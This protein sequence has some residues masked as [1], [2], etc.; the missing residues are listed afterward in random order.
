MYSKI[1]NNFTEFT[2]TN[3]YVDF[4]FFLFGAI[5]VKYVTVL[6]NTPMPSVG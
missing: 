1:S 4:F 2:P 6:A 3:K 5:M